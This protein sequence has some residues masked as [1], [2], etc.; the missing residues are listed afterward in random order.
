MLLREGVAEERLE[1]R[2]IADARY[3]GE[4]HEVRVPAPAGPLTVAVLTG[5]LEAFHDVHERTYGYAYRGE[6]PVEVVNLRVQAVGIVH[7]PTLASGS[8]NG[9]RGRSDAVER[10]VF[11]DGAGWLDVPIHA[12]SDLAADTGVRGP[13]VIEELGSTTVVFPGWAVRVDRL[14]NLIM[15]KEA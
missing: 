7:R 4:A 6:Q 9:G 13:A 5:L 10:P 3:L 1:L 8:A 2:R 12:R 15:G 14:G 11:F